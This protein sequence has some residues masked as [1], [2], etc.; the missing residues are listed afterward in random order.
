MPDFVRHHREHLRPR[1][2]LQ[3]CVGQQDVPDPRHQ[4][5]HRRVDHRAP[6]LPQHDVTHADLVAITNRLQIGP[7]LAGGHRSQTEYEPGQPR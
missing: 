5:D 3:Q 2:L 1:D 4:T 7:D 6:G